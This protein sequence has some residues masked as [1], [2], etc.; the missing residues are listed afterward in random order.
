[1]EWVEEWVDDDESNNGK[2]LHGGINSRRVSVV[3]RNPVV[4]KTSRG[5]CLEIL[6]QESMWLQACKLQQR[7]KEEGENKD[8]R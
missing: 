3:A 7:P 5:T 4:I 2:L 1:M 6:R 8:G